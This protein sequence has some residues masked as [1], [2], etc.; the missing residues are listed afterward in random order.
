MLLLLLLLF[1]IPCADGPDSLAA[2]GDQLQTALEV[3]ETVVTEVTKAAAVAAAAGGDIMQA[4]EE[5]VGAVG[6]AA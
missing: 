4:V 2:F 3:Q 1:Q 5:T 6:G